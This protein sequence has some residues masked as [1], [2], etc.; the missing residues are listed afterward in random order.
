MITVNRGTNFG[1]LAALPRLVSIAALLALAGCG[2]Q[3]EP[4]F[5]PSRVAAEDREQRDEQVPARERPV[6]IEGPARPEGAPPVVEVQAQPQA[7][8]DPRLMNPSQLTERA[9]D[10]FVAE[11]DTTEGPIRIEVHRDWAPNGA[12]RFYNL[13]RAGFFGDVAFF[14]VIDGFMAQGGIHGNPTVAA[15]WQRANIPDDPVVQHNTRGMVSYAM[16][17]PGSRT[18]QFFINLVDNSRLD[19]MGFAPFGR[20]LDMATVDRLYSGY[21]EGAPSGRGPA[22]ARIQREGNTYLR[23]DFPELD[24][25]RSARIAEGAG[26]RPA[27]SVPGAPGAARRAEG[28]P[29]R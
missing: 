5:R 27:G 8:I 28:S 7:A 21:G 3:D 12:D 26:A 10:V 25:I 1:R 17:G 15:A 14:R 2:G 6:Q 11:L 24:Y 20:V 18:T 9:P 16:A 23:A 4:S 22:Q 19:G 13:V 29:A